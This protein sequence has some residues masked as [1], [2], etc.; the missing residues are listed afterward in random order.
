MV[1]PAL[2]YVASTA[3][4]RGSAI[5][6][7]PILTRALTPEAYGLLALA[8][9]AASAL[10]VVETCGLRAALPKVYFDE[11]DPA[12][13]MAAVGSVARGMLLV[14][15]SVTVALGVGCASIGQRTVF[16]LGRYDVGLVLLACLGQAAAFVPHTVLRIRGQATKA[17]AFQLLQVVVYVPA[18]LL[19]VGWAKRGL[20]GALEASALASLTVGGVATAFT[21]GLPSESVVRRTRAALR[22]GLPFVPHMLASWAQSAGDRFVLGAYGAGADLGRYYLATQLMSPVDLVSQAWNDQESPRLGAAMRDRGPAGLLAEARARL[23]GFLLVASVAAL[24]IVVATPALRWIVGREF[25]GVGALMVPLAVA[26]VFDG[27]YFVPSVVAFYAGSAP[28]IPAV[29]VASAL[30][31]VALSAALLPTY[32]LGGLLAARI[33]ASVCRTA[34]MTAVATRSLRGATRAVAPRAVSA[35]APSPPTSRDGPRP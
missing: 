30:V 12:A 2:L 23:P 7:V 28:L 9:T 20:H 24:A 31:S 35:S 3:L 29:T 32:G 16:D 15:L 27:A 5:L 26:A 19:L 4:A 22:H 18:V 1:P 10:T 13:A 6:V 14:A 11:K 25:S 33:A 8:N 21:L 17:A 34:L